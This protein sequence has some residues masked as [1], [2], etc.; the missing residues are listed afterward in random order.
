MSN[1]YSDMGHF[2]AGSIWCHHSRLLSQSCSEFR[3]KFIQESSACFAT[4]GP[5]NVFRRVTDNIIDVV[6]PFLLMYGVYSWANS[7][8]IEM[9]RKK[10]SDFA[11]E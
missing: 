6:P 1:G 10:P 11:D 2:G 4:Q 7:T 3:G 8:S 5:A 9:H